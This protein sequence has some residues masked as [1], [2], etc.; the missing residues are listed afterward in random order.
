MELRLQPIKLRNGLLGALSGEE[1]HAVA[2][3]MQAIDLPRGF[4]LSLANV[5]PAF[6]YFLES[7]IGSIV[8]KSPDGNQAEVGLFGFDGMTPTTLVLDAGPPSH[9]IFMQVPGDGYC[10]PTERL[11]QIIDELPSLRRILLRYAHTLSLQTASTALSNAVHTVD[12]RL[13][14]WILMCDDRTDGNAI[15]LTHEFLAIMLAVRRASV[16][17]SLHVLEGN[18]LIEARRGMILVRDRDALE[19]FAG[20]AYGYP[21]EEYRRLIGPFHA[22]LAAVG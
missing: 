18:R 10:I 13:A 19:E 4:N 17:T 22:Q 2:E 9:S 7:G 8:A 20:D 16:T 6:C 15:A 21:E 3:H 11:A 5:D 12:E 14:R 1:L